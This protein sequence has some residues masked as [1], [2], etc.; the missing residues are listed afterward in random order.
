MVYV[1][2]LTPWWYLSLYTSG[3]YFEN[4]FYAVE[5][6]DEKYSNSTVGFYGQFYSG[7]TFSK[8]QTMTGDV[9]AVYLSDFIYGSYDYGNQFSL[10]LSVR[11]SFW[12]KTGSVTLGV[13]D[14]FDTYNVP[15]T[16]RYYNQDNS[17]FAQPESRLYRVS[18]KYT[19]GNTKLRDNNRDRKPEETTRLEK[20]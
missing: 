1:S 20:N 10:S 3:F 16:S 8:D 6:I 15:V 9:T 12:D 5:S 19:F 13:N 11:K 4:E 2:S 14:L 18:F 7:L 17:Y